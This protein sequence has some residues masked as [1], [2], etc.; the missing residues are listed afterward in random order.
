M[1]PRL[2]TTRTISTTATKLYGWDRHIWD[3]P[4]GMLV[5]GRKV[6]AAGQA[7]FV[8]A[9]GLGKLSILISYLRIAL[10]GTLFLRLTWTVIVVNTVSML[11]FFILLW[12]Q[13]R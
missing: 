2:I 11:A 10:K 8:F 7:F 9:S 1:V 12:A 5:Q 3:E 6:S 13:C 4:Y